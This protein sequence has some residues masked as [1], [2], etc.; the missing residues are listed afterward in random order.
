[1]VST[2]RAIAHST[3]IKYANKY[4]IPLTKANGSKKTIAELAK[5]IYN[6]EMRYIYPKRGKY[7]LYVI[8]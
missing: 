8:K 7:G 3:Y 6:Y 1:M 5:E 2:G 4:N